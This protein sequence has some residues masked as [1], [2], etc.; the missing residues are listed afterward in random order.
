MSRLVGF[1]ALALLALPLWGCDDRPVAAYAALPAPGESVPAFTF[2]TV[3]GRSLGAEDLRGQPAVLA[4]WSTTC[5]A[6]QL[7]LE[8]IELL[9][10]SYAPRG[11]RV[12]LFADDEHA[13][14][15]SAFAD[16]AGIQA[17]VVHAGGDLKRIFDRSRT[18]P[19]R[20]EARVK[21]A[22]PSFLVL[23][24]DGRVVHRAAGIAR[25]PEQ[26]LVH[27]RAALDS[28]LNA[29]TAIAAP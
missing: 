19:E 22:L 2:S 23:D 14:H 28:L 13:E 7:A 9:H 10:Q 15:L 20:G 24:R 26:R 16:S 1:F 4:L 27:V 17:E 6:S 29:R 3:E 18:A 5:S 21:F 25:E 8:S 11:V 12:V